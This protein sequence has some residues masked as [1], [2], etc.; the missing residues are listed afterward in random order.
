VLDGGNSSRLSNN[1]VR[2][3]EIANSASA[4]YS[5][6]GRHDTLFVLSAVPSDEVDINALE[7]ALREEIN[8]IKNQLPDD[9]ELARVKAQVVA[10]QVYK[11]DST[12]Y[13]AMEIGM[14][15]TIGLPWQIK[16]DYVE[17]ILAVSAEQ[18]Q[19]VATK[20]LTDERL[21]VAELA[22]QPIDRGNNGMGTSNSGNG[23]V[24]SKATSK[25]MDEKVS[26]QKENA[27][28]AEDGEKQ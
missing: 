1:L 11:Q 14:L 17:K 9:E 26:E 19:Q 10:A 21:T 5:M 4:S 18:V 27:V 8:V 20:Y 24:A 15:D 3:Q 2:G 23:D 7:S 25:A 13:Q 16:D 22:P 6:S 12:F 28:I